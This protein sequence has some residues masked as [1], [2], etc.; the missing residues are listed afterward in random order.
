MRMLVGGV[1]AVVL[2]A[3]GS[4]S[5]A[6]ITGNGAPSSD[7]AFAGGAAVIDFNSETLNAYTSLTTNGVTFGAAGREFLV[8]ATFAGDFNT[9]GAY[10]QNDFGGSSTLTFS[11]AAPV[12]AFAFNFGG[13]NMPWMLSAF[14]SGGDLLDSLEIPALVGSNG[15]DFFGISAAGIDHVLLTTASSDYVTLDNF[16]YTRVG[17]GPVPEPSAWA[18]MIGGFGLTGLA[19]RRRRAL[20]AA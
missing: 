6:V 15:P 8:D 18:L 11:F 19:L 1:A 13:S 14:G 17:A 5:A 9:E 3:A 10:L 12:A 2:A 4:V 7:P 16:T 20:A